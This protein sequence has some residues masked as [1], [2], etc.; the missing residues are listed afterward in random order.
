MWCIL[1]FPS[2]AIASADLMPPT[3]GYDT[4]AVYDGAAHSALSHT[5]EAAPV[6]SDK[7]A[8]SVQA[9]VSTATG[10][11]F[12]LF[13]LSVAADTAAEIPAYSRSA[14]GRVSAGDRAAALEETPTCPYCLKSPSTQVD[15]I[16]SLKQDW[17]SGGW[18]DD[19]ATRTARVNS[20]SNLTGACQACNG[21]AGKSAS[22]LGEGPG[23]WWPPA[24][25]SGTWWPSG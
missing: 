15:H 20:P 22:P 24:W 11:L 19:A 4:S 1:G 8:E 18:A 13:P 2:P 7:V 9:T 16:D 10:P 12:V 21:A 6:A 5:S 14:Y 17:Q 25:P 3:H 23:Q